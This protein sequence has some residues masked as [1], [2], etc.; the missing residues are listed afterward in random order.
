MLFF[1]NFIEGVVKYAGLLTEFQFLIELNFNLIQFKFTPDA[2]GNLWFC[3]VPWQVV[4][5]TGPSLPPLRL[6]WFEYLASF[7]LSFGFIYRRQLRL[8]SSECLYTN[9]M[10]KQLKNERKRFVTHNCFFSR[11]LHPLM[12]SLALEKKQSRCPRGWMHRKWA[13]R[14]SPS[15]VHLQVF[16]CTKS[17]ELL[18]LAANSFVFSFGLRF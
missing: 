14:Q 10:A 4:D 16:E 13:F 15:C 12:L 5:L 17:A 3:A 2:V 9:I 11:M 18:H 1:F 6:P 8:C 7:C